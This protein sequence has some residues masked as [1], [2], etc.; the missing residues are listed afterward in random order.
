MFKR[1]VSA[2]YTS[3]YTKDVT[4]TWSSTR[5]PRLQPPP[6]GG[7]AVRERNST[8]GVTVITAQGPSSRTPPSLPL[9]SAPTFRSP[10]RRKSPLQQGA[11]SQQPG[12]E[13]WPPAHR[14]RRQ[15]KPTALPRA[16]PERQRQEGAGE[17]LHSAPGWRGRGQS[18]C[19]WEQQSDL[20]TG[21]VTTP[22]TLAPPILSNIMDSEHFLHCR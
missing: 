20:H 16:P 9:P 17:Q 19:Q 6:H 14:D 22:D 12:Q 2:C 15:S 13:A 8:S 4:R 21:A 18:S 1:T 3:E 5:P 7:P 11:C 10:K